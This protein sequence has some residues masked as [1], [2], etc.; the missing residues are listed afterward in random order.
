MSDVQEISGWM[1]K[2]KTG[3][4]DAFGA[5]SKEIMDA[6]AVFIVSRMKTNRQTY[7]SAKPISI[8]QGKLARG[9]QGGEGTTD[10]GLVD[11]SAI[12]YERTIRVP[13]AG[14]SEFGGRV[15]ATPSM[16]RAMFAK[17]K[18]MGRYN[19]DTVWTHK[20]IFEHKP[21]EF[22]K[23]SVEG[24]TV[25]KITPAIMRHVEKELNKIPNIEVLL[26]SK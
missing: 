9:I 2:I 26:V 20:A 24:M 19:K 11:D 13:Y 7:P 22:I 14:I 17:L 4:W 25:D 8:F 6:W 12:V 15:R 23:D 18:A 16:R 10:D 1:N 21:F 5:S 3:I